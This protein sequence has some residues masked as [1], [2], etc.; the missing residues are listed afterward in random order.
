MLKQIAGTVSLLMAV[1]FIAGCNAQEKKMDKQAVLQ[2]VYDKAFS[3]ELEKISEIG[4][5]DV[6]IGGALPAAGAVGGFGLA[7]AIADVTIDMPGKFNIE[8]RAIGR[9]ARK[10]AKVGLIGGGA[11]AG[12][13]LLS[14]ALKSTGK[15]K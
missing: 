1:V 8:Q 11:L 4:V 10:G 2:E 3:D 9:Y 15:N 14:K 12:S 6:A 5:G 7:R 13:Y